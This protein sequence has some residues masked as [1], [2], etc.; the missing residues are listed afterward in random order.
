MSL[1]DGL[2][3][4]LYVLWRGP[5]YSHEIERE[6][7]FHLE[8]ASLAAEARDSQPIEAELAARRAFGNATYYREEVRRMIPLACF[9]HLRQDLGYAWR[10]L[11]RAPGFTLAVVLTLGL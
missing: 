10:G 6:A 9:D 1:I 2:K 7:H 5:R 3:H 4:R 11:T 8:L